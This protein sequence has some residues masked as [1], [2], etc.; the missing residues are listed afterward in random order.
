MDNLAALSDFR[1]RY[2][3]WGRDAEGGVAVEEPVAHDTLLLEYLH[4]AIEV[5]R[6]AKL[7]GKQKS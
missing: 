7:Y 4:K 2:S 6:L 1:L 3:E 5:L